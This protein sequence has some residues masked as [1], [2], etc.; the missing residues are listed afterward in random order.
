MFK[1]F[2]TIWFYLNIIQFGAYLESIFLFILFYIILILIPILG[3]FLKTW[4]IIFHILF[5]IIIVINYLM[6]YLVYFDE[7]ARGLI[8]SF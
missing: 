2:F 5:L 1:G 8:G 4:K 7:I 6:V 3:F